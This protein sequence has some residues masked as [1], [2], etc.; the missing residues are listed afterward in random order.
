MLESKNPGLQRSEHQDYVGQFDIHTSIWLIYSRLFGG[1][2]DAHTPRF[3]SGRVVLGAWCFSALMLVALYT[4][5]L[6]AFMVQREKAYYIDG[7]NDSRIRQPTDS[8]K[9]TTILETSVGTYFKN[10]FPQ[11]YKFMEKQHQ[12]NHS[13]DGVQAVLDG[14]IEAF[15]WET[16]SLHEYAAK[17][18][19]CRLLVAGKP[20]DQ[21][22]Y[23]AV[24][25]KNSKWTRNVTDLILKYQTSSKSK[26]MH[27]KWQKSYCDTLSSTA[28]IQRL[29]PTN[30]AG[31]FYMLLAG[32]EQSRAE[33]SRAEQSRAEQSR[34]EQSRAEQSR[35]EQSSNVI[36]KEF[37]T[38][39]T[40]QDRLRLQKD[41]SNMED[42]LHSSGLPDNQ[43]LLSKMEQELKHTLMELQELQELTEKSFMN[44]SFRSINM[45][46]WESSRSQ[47][48]L[49][50]MTFSDMKQIIEAARNGRSTTIRESAV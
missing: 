37:P 25:Q 8:L 30:L 2:L 20:F 32:I 14:K 15:I 50:S 3:V 9:F 44:S 22:G 11:T 45:S 1:N 36:F 41:V 31:V 38:N 27:D 17:D 5:N 35:A 39:I 34:A 23:A 7:I 13:Q 49:G 21:T 6:A 33:Q 12:V 48:A 42:V 10:N 16:V 4:A 46:D 19:G 47:D 24:F 43:Q 29:G 40:E 18:P 26:E 28:T